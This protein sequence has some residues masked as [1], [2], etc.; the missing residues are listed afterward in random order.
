MENLK[1][2]NQLIRGFQNAMLEMF[3]QVK[4][5]DYDDMETINN[6]EDFYQFVGEFSTNELKNIEH[7]NDVD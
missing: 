3:E 5:T 1:E 4:G 6:I 2:E 7:Y